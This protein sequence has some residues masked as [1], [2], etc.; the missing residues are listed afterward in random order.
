V[1]QGDPPLSDA[2]LKAV[3][4]WR[5]E[6]LLV[7]GQPK[8]FVWTVRLNFVSEETL[9]LDE[10]ISSL[11]SR[12]E[13]VRESAVVILGGLFTSGRDSRERRWT[14]GELKKVLERDRSPRVRKAA[15][16]ALSRLGLEDRAGSMPVHVP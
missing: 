6:P 9:R 11:S 15:R 7:G 1:V 4:K 16:E 13:A 12:Y 3:R 14:V 5:Y 10:L 2:A 8:A